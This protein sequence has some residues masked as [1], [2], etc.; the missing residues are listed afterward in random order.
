MLGAPTQKAIVLKVKRKHIILDVCLSFKK[1][2]KILQ[3]E[4]KRENKI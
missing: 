3:F 4:T 1:M 2:L